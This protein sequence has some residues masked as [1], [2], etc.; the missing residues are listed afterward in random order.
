M[1][2]FSGYRDILWER[3]VVEGKK[4]IVLTM[5]KTAATSMG[6]KEQEKA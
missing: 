2:L 4:G 1:I 6:M 3:E 5:G